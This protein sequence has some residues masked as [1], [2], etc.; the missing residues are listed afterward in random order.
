MNGRGRANAE[1]MGEWMVEKGIK[2]DAVI[3]S[4][5]KRAQE[6]WKRVKKV[7]GEDATTI[8]ADELYSSGPDR[9]LK[10]L[11]TA[12]EEAR[13]VLMIGHQPVMSSFARKLANGSTPSSCARAYKKFPTAAVAVIA[14]K[15]EKW[16]DVSF[17]NAD[18]KKFVCPKEM[19]DS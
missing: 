9:M 18:F 2:P 5:T 16:D 4:S 19:A 7:L 14:P 6:T 3:T 12:P 8:V 17:G 15:A 13:T 10:A 11:H 1:L